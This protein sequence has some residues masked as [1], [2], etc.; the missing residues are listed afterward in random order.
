MTEQVPAITTEAVTATTYPFSSSAGVAL[1]DMS[2]GTTQ[3]VAANLDDNAS[4]VTN[5]GFD[6]WYDGV[7]FTQFS[8]NANGLAR[9]GGTAVSTSDDDECAEDCS[10]L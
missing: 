5:L 4:P 9:L 7:R 1:E 6:F 3:L 8:V 10:L 2:T